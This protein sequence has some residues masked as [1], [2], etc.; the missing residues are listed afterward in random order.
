MPPTAASAS[1]DL[2]GYAVHNACVELNKRLE[3]Y[4]QKLGYDASLASLAAA[5]WRDRVSLSAS[6]YYKAPDLGYEWK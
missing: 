6:G 2:S 5:A 3:P 1:S 4:R